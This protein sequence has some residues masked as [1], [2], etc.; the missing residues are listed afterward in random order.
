MRQAYTEDQLV[1]Q[2]AIGLFEDLGPET[3]SA[4]EARTS[5]LDEVTRNRSAMSPAATN[6]GG[7]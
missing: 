6:R 7:A 5:A 4:A 3:V 1:A 2:G